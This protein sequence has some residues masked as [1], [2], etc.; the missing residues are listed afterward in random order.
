VAPESIIGADGRTQVVSPAIDRYP[1]R[2]IGRVVATFDGQ[3]VGC[4]GFLIGSDFVLTAAHC[5]FWDPPGGPNAT[6]S[7]P[8]TFTFTP[9]QNGAS[10]PHG[11]CAGQ[12]IYTTQK[13]RTHHT[14]QQDFAGVQLAHANGC[15]TVG[16][17]LGTFGILAFADRDHFNGWP[18]TVRGYP[19]DKPAGTMWTMKDRVERSQRQMLFYDL[20]TDGG[21]SGGPLYTYTNPP[22]AALP[23]GYYA[24]GVH[25]YGAVLDFRPCPCNAA[26][27]ITVA[28]VGL[29]Q[30]WMAGN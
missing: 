9:G 8:T 23:A 30:D 13:W 10:A 20:D 3:T 4:T 2:A 24:I 27:R 15:G 17:R 28:R 7:Y 29:I 19:T 6:W 16:D 14:P 5:A 21:Q 12:F 18:A 22:G 26:A 1:S 25:A 11:S